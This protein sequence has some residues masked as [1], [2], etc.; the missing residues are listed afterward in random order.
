MF[1]QSYITV[2]SFSLLNVLHV[3]WCNV[4]W[5]DVVCTVVWRMWYG[6]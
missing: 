1:V 2:E 5:N 6:T 4:V 3:V